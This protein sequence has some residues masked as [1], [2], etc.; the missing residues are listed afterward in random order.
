MKPKKTVKMLVADDDYE[1]HNHIKKTLDKNDIK[2]ETYFVTTGKELIE[3]LNNTGIYIDKKKYPRPGIII[4][5][6]AMPEKDGITALK[7]IKANENLKNIPIIILSNSSS[8]EDISKTYSL[9]VSG[10]IT[11]PVNLETLSETIKIISRYWFEIVE[12]PS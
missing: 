2:N 3:F 4:L 6:L 1:L 11:K 12:L 8:R 7:E 10:Y 9:G 5:D